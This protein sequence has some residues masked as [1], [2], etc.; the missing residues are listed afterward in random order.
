MSLVHDQQCHR[1]SIIPTTSPRGRNPTA[2]SNRETRTKI[3]SFPCTLLHYRDK[4][5]DVGLPAV[6]RDSI[7][8]PAS[9]RKQGSPFRIPASGS[10]MTFQPQRSLSSH[11][12]GMAPDR[13]AQEEAE[14]APAAGF[15]QSCACSS[16]PCTAG[17]H[18][19]F[20]GELPSSPGEEEGKKTA[21]SE[22]VG[23]KHLILHP[24]HLWSRKRV[25]CLS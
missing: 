12:K 9:L 13:Q 18:T 24:R 19:R 16:A 2:T 20:S 17:G 1:A 8:H 23:Q 15:A 21:G 11:G 10:L 14:P 22:T 6:G 7:S 3:Q 4:A 5:A 25:C